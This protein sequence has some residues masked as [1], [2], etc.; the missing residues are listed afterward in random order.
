MNQW[1]NKKNITS[2][3]SEQFMN[4]YVNNNKKKKQ[5]YTQVWIYF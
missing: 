3:V 4:G 1:M 5:F 2:Q